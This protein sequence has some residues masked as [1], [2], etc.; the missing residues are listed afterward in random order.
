[1]VRV[2]CDALN[3][4]D[5]TSTFAWLDFAAVRLGLNVAMWHPSQRRKRNPHSLKAVFFFG[6]GGKS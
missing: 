4:A 5:L 1:M 2:R 3:L 6:W